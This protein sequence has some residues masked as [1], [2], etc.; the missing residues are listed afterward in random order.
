MTMTMK[1]KNITTKNVTSELLDKIEE[2]RPVIEAGAPNAEADRKLS[3]EVFDA[4]YDAGL[5][6]LL[7][8]KAYG[9]FELPI[10]EVMRVWE[11]LTKIDSAAGWNLV[12]NQ[13]LASFIAWL[14]DD[15]AGELMAGGPATVAGGF[16]P[17]GTATRAD[18]GWEVTSR[19]PF[20][21]GCHNAKWHWLPA[22]ETEDGEPV[23]DPESGEPIV[24]GFFIP[25]KKEHIYDT[26]H[27]LGM[28]GTGSADIG[29]SG[30]FVPDQRAM[31]MG[32]LQKAA[33]GFE[34]P[35]YRLFPLSSVLGETVVSLGV[36]AAAIDAILELA[37]VKTPA[38]TETSLRDQPIT[39][40]TIGRAA[41]KVNASRDTLYAAAGEAYDELEASGELLSWDAK[42]RLQLAI[43]FTVGA[44]TEA[45]DLVHQT[46]GSSAIRHEQPFERLFRDAHTLTQHASKNSARHVTTGRLLFG[47]ENDWTALAF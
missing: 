16:F 9:G 20:A 30:I 22:L 24:Y 26:W 7:A 29:V 19:V 38:F 37:E 41:A 13:G 21:S 36:A 8:P 27:T 17:P 40:Y 6:G 5:F 44:C 14:P 32:P 15:G 35:L 23:M 43:N 39:Q 1:T 33:T 2:I 3:Q 25:N 42:V 12:M 34:G 45:V 28:R 46:A 10:T 18:G 4:M 31:R 47:L 11:T